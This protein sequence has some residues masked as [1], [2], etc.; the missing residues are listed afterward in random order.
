MI[1][2]KNNN[3][4]ETVKPDAVKSAERVNCVAATTAAM[5]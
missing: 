1:Q 3:E 2:H 5:M 4:T